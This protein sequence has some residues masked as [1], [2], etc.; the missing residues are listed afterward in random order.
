MKPE[1]KALG[2]FS[3]PPHIFFTECEEFNLNV[4]LRAE[5]CQL[6][7]AAPAQAPVD[8]AFDEIMEMAA[9]ADPSTAPASLYANAGGAPLGTV[10]SNAATVLYENA[11]R[12]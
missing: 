8:D 11:G 9:K 3:R 10:V 4:N 5:L 2:V 7:G 1:L 12:A 6:S